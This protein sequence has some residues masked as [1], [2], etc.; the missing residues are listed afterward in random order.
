MLSTLSE[1][2][3]IPTFKKKDVS[4]KNIVVF[5]NP[6]ARA[7]FECSLE[8]LFTMRT[9]SVSGGGVNILRNYK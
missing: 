7:T 6:S 3:I 4:R 5:S 2:N 1:N 9:V 8:S